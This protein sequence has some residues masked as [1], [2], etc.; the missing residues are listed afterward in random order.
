[1]TKPTERSGKPRGYSTEKRRPTAADSQVGT[2]IR[3]HRLIAGMSQND[4]AQRLGVS[5]QQV[6][7][8]EKGVNRVG[9]GRL[10]QIADVFG[11]P[12]SALF[13]DHA[14]SSAAPVKLVT[15]NATVRLLTAFADITDQA[16][17][18]NLSELVE[19]IANNARKRSRR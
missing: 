7:K 14:G 3:A 1:M 19:R 17:R 5:F 4:L 9:A 15:D 18:R 12:I 10:P 6:Q 16:I 2:S 8:Y 13:R 11:I